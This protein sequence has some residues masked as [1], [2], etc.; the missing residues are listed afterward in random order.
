MHRSLNTFFKKRD[1]GLWFLSQLRHVGVV[2]WIRPRKE[3][4]DYGERLCI[5]THECGELD[6][7]HKRLVLIDTNLH[8]FMIVEI[9][10]ISQGPN[11]HLS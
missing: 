5:A 6:S 1:K 10:P 7:W 3:T 4:W 9:I 8:I 11:T 2:S